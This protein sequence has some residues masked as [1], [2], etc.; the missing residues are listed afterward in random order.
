MQITFPMGS[1]LDFDTNMVAFPVDVDGKRLRCLVSAE[2]LQDHFD[3]V[4]A[5]LVE[6]F[7]A[8]RG[9]VELVAAEKIKAGMT[10][11]IR[12]KTTDF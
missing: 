10:S 5:D 2:A 4:G 8:N 6:V 12:L 3:G 7:E 9:S 11:P 1:A